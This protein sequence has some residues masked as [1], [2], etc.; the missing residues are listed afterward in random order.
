MGAE[1][2]GRIQALG[3]GLGMQIWGQNLGGWSRGGLA[4]GSRDKSWSVEGSWRR[5]SK[6]QGRSWS[7]REWG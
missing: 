7:P 3:A 5:S 4:Q 2:E 6:D 1:R